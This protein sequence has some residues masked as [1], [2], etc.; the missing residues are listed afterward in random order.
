MARTSADRDEREIDL[1]ELDDDFLLGFIV[2][3]EESESGASPRAYSDNLKRSFDRRLMKEFAQFRIPARVPHIWMLDELQSVLGPETVLVSAFLGH[4]PSGSTCIYL[5]AVAAEWV[6]CRLVEQLDL[7]QGLLQLDID[8]RTLLVHPLT[9][10]VAE[11]RSAVRAD[12][13]HRDV[14][15]EADELLTAEAKRFLGGFIDRFADWR[16]QGKRHLC[17]W[18]HGPLH[19]LPFHLLT[20]DGNPLAEDWAISY[21]RGLTSLAPSAPTA[22]KA[23][24]VVAIGSATGAPQF[25]LTTEPVVEEQAASIAEN[26]G[27]VALI[28]PRATRRAVLAT[29]PTARYLHIGAHGAHDLA[30]SLFHRLYL[31]PDADDQNDGRLYAYDLIGLDLRGVEMVTLS[32]CESALGRFDLNDNLVGIPA[33]LLLSG[34]SSLVVALWPVHPD[35]ASRFFHYLYDGIQSGLDRFAAFRSAQLAVRSDFPRYRDWGAFCYIGSWSDSAQGG[36]SD[37]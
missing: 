5:L 12:P 4:A 13:L 27:G 9:G 14:S 30:A 37:D 17:F 36:M 32:A 8:N 33:A 16:S 20:V 21:L 25:G 26:L 7:D 10:P 19:F 34:V 18:G 2:G 35:A 29:L 31:H 15:R 22:A 3:S 23:V 24:P 11:I 28:G 6:E 1:L